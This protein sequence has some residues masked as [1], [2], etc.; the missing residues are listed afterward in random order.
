MAN[1]YVDYT[2]TAAQQYFAFN[3]PYL[4][5]EHVVVEIE[6][7]DQTITTNYTIETSPTQRIN[8]SNPTT[9]LAGGELVRIKRRSAPNT[10]LVDFQNGSVLTES[11]LDRAYLHNRY[12]AEEATEGADSGLKELEGSTN[13]NAGNKQIKNL[14]DG[15]LATDAVNKGYIDTQIALTDTNLAGFYKST[16][17]GNAVDNV[18]TLSFTPQTTDAKAYIV[19]IDGLVQVPDTDYTIG[20]TAITFNTIPAN[21]AEICV[22]ATA[23]AS[24]ATVNEAQVTAL[25]TSDTRS[26]AT[27]TRDLG[28]PI[29][30]GSTTA[31]SIADRFGDV[32]H[33]KDFGAVGDGETD[34]TDAILAAISSANRIDFSGGSYVYS[35]ALTLKSNLKLF[36]DGTGKLI[37]S[38]ASR[39]ISTQATE[40]SLQATQNLARGDNH[41]VLSAASYADVVEGDYVKMTTDSTVSSVLNPYTS[42]SI[43]DLNDIDND[44][45]QEQAFKILQ[46]IGSNTVL[47]DTVA[48]STFLLT[49]AGAVYK[50]SAVTE[51]VTIDNL[52]FINADTVPDTNPEDA[53]INIYDVY[54][55]NI[56][57]CNFELN[58]KTGGLFYSWGTC[59]IHNNYFVNTKQLP[60]YFREGIRSSSVANNKFLAS[61]SSDG[62]LFI[63]AFCYNISVTGNSFD[64]SY[65]LYEGT[66]GIAGIDLSARASQINITGNSIFGYSSGVRSLFGAMHNTITGNTFSN[67]MTFG[68]VCSSSPATVISSNTFLNCA[69]NPSPSSGFY[70]N[71]QA[72]INTLNSV[73]LVISDNIITS[74]VA[75]TQ[76]ILSGSNNTFKS[77]RIKGTSGIVIYGTHINFHGNYVEYNGTSNAITVSGVGGSGQGLYNKIYEN[78]IIGS[79]A[80]AL[81]VISSNAECN[82]IYNNKFNTVG[83][84]VFLSTTVVQSIHNNINNY[85]DTTTSMSFI[86]TQITAPVMPSYS[87]IPRNFRIYEVLFTPSPNGGRFWE[88]ARTV[89]ATNTFNLFD[90]SSL[91]SAV[92][93]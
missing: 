66:E 9:A 75:K 2:A 25:G 49:S 83:Y 33:V 12:L 27:W 71:N 60:I 56:L 65:A 47:L 44:I 86:N 4:E 45:Y 36:S 92:T 15:T 54:D 70:A 74:D 39:I 42:A 53:L 18:F 37:R 3:F 78:H 24:V 11:E 55:L 22:V 87:T 90:F 80:N 62:G 69:Q 38:N 82:E 76:V 16:H 67:C 84:C 10:N 61:T 35:S 57:N 40:T 43:S 14:A 13:Y 5:D 88:F 17:T 85:S 89:G 6:G 34:D 46:K 23:A 50:L 20:A 48:K 7:V 26:L 68:V 58:E 1:T 63:Q 91:V 81:I 31:R 64:G 79:T 19:S 21:S 73:Q 8:L 77:N 59:S 29:A 32:I 30:T 51:N 28:T 52:T 93:V 41:L 72:T